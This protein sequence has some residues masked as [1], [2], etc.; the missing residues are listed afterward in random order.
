MLIQ[1]GFGMML[2]LLYLHL[3]EKQEETPVAFMSENNE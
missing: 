3:T 1:A 2:L